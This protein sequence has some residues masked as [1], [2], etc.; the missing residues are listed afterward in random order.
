MKNGMNTGPTRT[1]TAVATQPNAM[2]ATSATRASVTQIATSKV[3]H[4]LH[5]VVEHRLLEGDVDLVQT[6]AQQLHLG[7]LQLRGQRLRLV[8]DQVRKAAADA[9]NRPVVERHHRESDRDGE[10]Q[11]GK[12]AEGHALAFGA[13]QSRSDP[14]PGDQNRGEPA[15]H[16]RAHR[17]EHVA[18]T[19][20]QL[21]DGGA[22]ERERIGLGHDH[23]YGKRKFAR[24]SAVPAELCRI[25][26]R[27]WVSKAIWALMAIASASR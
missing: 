8:G 12:A 14:E 26:S 2:T 5:D 24:A 10:Q 20:E 3:P 6:V 25:R 27:V 9:G 22:D 16:V 19:R 11:T 4:D 23:S 15:E 18:V 21:D 17:D 13:G 7:R 1:A